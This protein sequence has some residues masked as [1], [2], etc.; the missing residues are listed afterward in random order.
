MN[1]NKVEGG[2]WKQKGKGD[3]TQGILK[4]TELL[5][6]GCVHTKSVD[7]FKNGWTNQ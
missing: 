3:S 1:K 4:V 7:G 5:A 2:Q 6:L